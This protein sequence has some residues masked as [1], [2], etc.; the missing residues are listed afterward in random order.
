MKSLDTTVAVDYLRGRTQAAELVEGLIGEGHVLIASEI[1]RLELL[2]GVREQART[3][4]EFF[5]S[6][7]SWVPVVEEVARAA[8]EL[9]RHYRATHPGIDDPDYLIA[10]TA[11][12]L[13][14]ELLTT[15]VKH[16]PMLEELEP[17]Y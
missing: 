14:A 6:A 7:L 15:D 4:L 5:C 13:D 8:G 10:A 1:V 3:A 17:A 16:F 11:L 2:A 9:A 12:I